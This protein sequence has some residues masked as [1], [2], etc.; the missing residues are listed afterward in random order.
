MGRAPKD[1]PATVAQQGHTAVLSG[2]DRVV[3]GNPLNKVQKVASRVLPDRV[4]ASV[5]AF[6]ARPR[7]PKS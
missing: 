5:H 1:D 3:G 7:P 6:L 4:R 2:D